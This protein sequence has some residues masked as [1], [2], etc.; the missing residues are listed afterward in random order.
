MN[1]SILRRFEGDSVRVV[2]EAA[3]G[4]SLKFGYDPANELF[5]IARSLPLGMAYPFDWG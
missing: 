3:R 2:V 5:T 1:L 4:S